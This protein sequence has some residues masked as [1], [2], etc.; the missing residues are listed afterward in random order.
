MYFTIFIT[1]NDPRTLKNRYM[2]KSP[3]AAQNMWLG[4]GTQNI[5]TRW[6]IYQ[7][8]YQADNHAVC[9][10]QTLHE[11]AYSERCKNSHVSSLCAATP[12]SWESQFT[13]LFLSKPIYLSQRSEHQE[14]RSGSKAS[15]AIAWT[16]KSSRL[17][18][19]ILPVYFLVYSRGIKL[20]TL[21]LLSSCIDISV[22]R[23]QHRSFHPVINC[24]LWN[25]T[26]FL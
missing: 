16:H 23:R 9:I 12:C 6:S 10:Y 25:R 19:A 7:S 1:P 13:T 18:I 11:W 24:I 4:I 26:S 14:A 3:V 21:R 8:Q 20:A 15:C 2:S 22:S 5:G 17:N